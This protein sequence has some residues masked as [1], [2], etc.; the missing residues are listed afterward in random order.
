MDKRNI[1]TI[2]LAICLL[3]LLTIGIAGALQVMRITREKEETLGA[4]QHITSLEIVEEKPQKP[5]EIVE[6]LVNEYAQKHETEIQDSLQG[7]EENDTPEV[8]ELPTT[9]P[10]QKPTQE[11]TSEPTA[12]PTAVPAKDP[13][14]TP[15]PTPTPI[16]IPTAT[17]FVCPKPAGLTWPGSALEDGQVV[18]MLDAGHGGHDSGTMTKDKKVYEKTINLNVA[19]KMKS[20]LEEKGITVL[21]TRDQDTFVSLEDRAEYCNSRAADLFVSIHVNSYDKSSRIGGLECYYYPGSVPC[22][23]LAQ[24]VVNYLSRNTTIPTRGVKSQDYYVLKGT[25]C[26]AILVEMGYITNPTDAANL[27]SEEF[28]D[29]MAQSLTDAIVSSLGM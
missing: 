6:S 8:T 2:I 25:A 20:L 14:P 23:T 18:V 24:D 7:A 12:K 19:Q 27:L 21:M 13:E 17:P 9:A 4:G 11:P 3:L 29:N 1:K 22:S 10:T 28:L 26:T 5:E 16:P 15:I